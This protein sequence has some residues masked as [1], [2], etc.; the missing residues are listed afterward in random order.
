MEILRQSKGVHPCERNMRKNLFSSMKRLS[1][2]KRSPQFRRLIAQTQQ[3]I[4]ARKPETII[5][6]RTNHPNATLAAYTPMAV[7]TN[8]FFS[9][10]KSTIR[11]RQG[12]ERPT[13]L[14]CHR[15]QLQLLFQKGVLK[16]L[17]CIRLSVPHLHI[18][19]WRMCNPFSQDLVI[20]SHL[21]VVS[22]SR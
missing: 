11:H 10:E 13:Q 3:H 1:S 22:L 7:K 5:T 21:A 2:E 6:S 12:S 20:T 16:S 8:E 14:W 18:F 9:P 4:A 17:T 19:P 15:L